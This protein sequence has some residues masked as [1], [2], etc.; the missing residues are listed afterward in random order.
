MLTLAAGMSRRPPDAIRTAPPQRVAI[1][2]DS[3]ARGAGDESHRGIGGYLSGVTV[4]N[5]GV[6]GARTGTVLRHLRSRTVR[7]A[8]SGADT[9][10]LSIGGNDLFGDSRARLL[11]TFAPELAMIRT[12]RRVRRVVAAVRRENSTARIYLLGLYNPYRAAWLDPFIAR[13]DARLTG[14]SAEMRG[15]TVVRVADLLDGAGRLSPIDRFHPSAA[16]YRA[17]A[18]RV[19]GGW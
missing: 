6:N 5:L 9:I 10:I 4:T 2:G 18:G 17:I 13:W 3:V 19:G 15:V 14:A 1:L 12:E 7:D 16:G 11:T 8:L